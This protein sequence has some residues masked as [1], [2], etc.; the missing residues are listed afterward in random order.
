M[1]NRFET[2]EWYGEI[3]FGHYFGERWLSI[4]SPDHIEFQT[5]LKQIRSSAEKFAGF[6]LYVVGGLLEPRM[7]WDIDWVITGE[8]DPR[9]IRDAL[10]V[11][12]RIGFSLGLYPDARY[13]PVIFDPQRWQQHGETITCRS[14]ILSNIFSK[15][16]V[17]KDL[18]RLKFQDGLYFDVNHYPF[19]KTIKQSESGQLA[20]A[21][22]IPL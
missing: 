7:S 12:T 6:D 9:R 1:F 5:Y 20:A 16:G 3:R 11:L 4:A 18:S 10:N 19:E 13:Q 15:N 22:H 8:Y 21:R 17:P 14:Y 2:K